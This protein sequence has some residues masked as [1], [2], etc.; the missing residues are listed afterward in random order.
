MSIPS[1]SDACLKVDEMIS[2]V[3]EPQDLRVTARATGAGCTPVKDT[4][5]HIT[6]AARS[7]C[8]GTL[9]RQ[10]LSHDSVY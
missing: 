6:W 9:A 4:G 1:L 7:G 5:A 8:A 3:Y 2:P 10:P